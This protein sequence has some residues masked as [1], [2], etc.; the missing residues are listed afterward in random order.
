[1][2]QFPYIII[3]AST[4]F[5]AIFWFIHIKEEAVESITYFPIDPNSTYIE[6]NTKISDPVSSE[7]EVYQFEVKTQSK[8]N[9]S[10]Y[11]RQD[12]SLLFANGRLVGKMG[13]WEEQTDTIVNEH[14][15]ILANN[16]LL[17]AVTFHHS[18]IHYDEQITS[19]Q[20]MSSDFLYVT[21]T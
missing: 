4:L 12:I 18:E 16:R 2:R 7:N 9:K 15:F 20:S 6:A 11:L 13:K 19:V 10:A 17:K 3:L 21:H 5:T 1:M 8:L 14:L